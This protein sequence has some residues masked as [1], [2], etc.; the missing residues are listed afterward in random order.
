[1]FEVFWVPLE[2]YE[3]LTGLNQCFQSCEALL[4]TTFSIPSKQT[5]LL[6]TKVFYM[7]EVVDAKYV[8]TAPKLA[9]DSLLFVRLF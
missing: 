4:L 8:R 7:G 3:L 1:M 6:S 9:P 5:H 2:F